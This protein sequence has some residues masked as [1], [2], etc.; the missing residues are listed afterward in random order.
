MLKLART[1][2][3]IFC[4]G[5]KVFYRKEVFLLELISLSPVLRILDSDLL[6]SI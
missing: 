4:L 2:T 5:K 6:L 1:N 3:M